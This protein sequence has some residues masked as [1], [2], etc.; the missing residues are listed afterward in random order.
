MLFARF[1]TLLSDS[2]ELK[3]SALFAVDLDNQQFNS[4]Y[5]KS[6][7][8]AYTPDG[9]LLG[10]G[11]LTDS[12]KWDLNAT[13][14]GD[15]IDILFIEVWHDNQLFVDHVKNVSVG[16]TFSSQSG[17]I[18]TGICKTKR[19][20][21]IA[22]R[23]F[24]HN[25]DLQQQ[26]KQEEPFNL[27]VKAE[28][29][30]N[31]VGNSTGSRNFNSFPYLYKRGQAYSGGYQPWDKLA[32]GY[33]IAKTY[34]DTDPINQGFTLCLFER[35]TNQPYIYYFNQPTSNFNSGDTLTIH[36]SDFVKGTQ[37]SIQVT[38]SSNDFNNIFLRNYN[39]VSGRSDLITSFDDITP[40]NGKTVQYFSS[41][42]LPT[43]YWSFFYSAAQNK[44]SYS[45]ITNSTIPASIEVKE[46]TGQSIT[47]VGDKF[48]L[49]HSSKAINIELARSYV[50][51]YKNNTNIY[52]S[53]SR[54]FDGGESI[55]T[56]SFKLFAIPTPILA[57]HVGFQEL[58][59][60]NEW[61]A[62]SYNQVY[63]NV[64]GNSSLEN[65]IYGLSNWGN[66]KNKSASGAYTYETF[67]IGL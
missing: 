67:S 54:F 19:Y 32:N 34:V 16:Q 39:S 57:N 33:T 51:F 43:T 25:M 29:F 42:N 6:F 5:Q 44:T 50:T 27:I 46:L 4:S 12:S 64:A 31:R 7:L 28:D 3:S 45:L 48:E 53:Y 10:Y 15:K 26:N 18:A 55:G 62:A 47:K 24:I 49:T 41:E 17:R 35:G 1:R 60:T 56:S 8:A 66:E 40:A 14:N 30:G 63:T 59:A 11:S 9:A 52:F 2:P 37:N 21:E 22:A 58:N 65:F 61:K 20:E 38:S 23:E 13:Y 36:K